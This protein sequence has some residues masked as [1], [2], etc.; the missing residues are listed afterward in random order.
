MEF[1]KEKGVMINGI[2]YCDSCSDSVTFK[3]Y[4]ESFS[5]PLSSLT[6]QEKDGA[7]PTELRVQME[8]ALVKHSEA[9]KLLSL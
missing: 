2:T 9:L 4:S 3:D 8:R 5:I 6:P 7:M 1:R